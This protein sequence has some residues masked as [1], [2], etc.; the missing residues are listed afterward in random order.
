YTCYPVDLLNK[1]FL[2]DRHVCLYDAQTLQQLMNS[3][4]YENIT[5]C[6][7]GESCHAAL[8]G[9]EGH[10]VG[11]IADEFTCVVEATKPLCSTLFRPP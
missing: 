7:V 3:V 9:I 11:S 8:S 4:G 2:E 6:K 5:L 10:D 1:A